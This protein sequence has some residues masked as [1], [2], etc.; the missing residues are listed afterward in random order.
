MK[1]RICFVLTGVEV[2]NI[3]SDASCDATQWPT[4]AANDRVFICSWD[5]QNACASMH[6]E[7]GIDLVRP[8]NDRFWWCFV[9]TAVHLIS[10]FHR[11]QVA[12]EWRRRLCHLCRERHRPIDHRCICIHVAIALPARPVVAP[13]H[14]ANKRRNVHKQPTLANPAEHQ[15][16]VF[17]FTLVESPLRR[18]ERTPLEEDSQGIER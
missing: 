12:L 6:F 8:R 2:Q 11:Q 17:E 16:Q 3:S 14:P 1:H 10:I 7:S 5:Y 9:R 4:S 18:L 13:A 15:C